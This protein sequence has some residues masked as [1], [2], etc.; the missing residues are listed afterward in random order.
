MIDVAELDIF[1]SGQDDIVLLEKFTLHKDN[2]IDGGVYSGKI[3]MNGISKD[4][5]LFNVRVPMSYPFS[6]DSI[7]IRFVCLNKIGL[8]HQNSDN[9]IC[10]V[11]PKNVNAISRLKNEIALLKEW[12]DVYYIGDKVDE[13]YDYL[14]TDYRDGASY[15]FTNLDKKFSKGQYGEFKYVELINHT[16]VSPGID[17]EQALI[18]EIGK[19][20]CAWSTLVHKKK[21]KTGWY[22][23]IDQE[24]LG[25]GI[26][27]ASNWSDLLHYLPEGFKKALCDF[28]NSK[29]NSIPVLRI[30]LG[31]NI[32]RTNEIHWQLIKIAKQDIP[33]RGVKDNNSWISELSHEQEIYW[34]KTYNASYDRFFGRGML[35]SQLAN[36]KVLICGAGAIGSSLA[37]I[38]CRGGL[39][40]LH[41][42]DNDLIEPGNICRSDYLLLENNLMKSDAMVRML[43]ATSP[44]IEAYVVDKVPKNL[45]ASEK[46]K[47]EKLLSRY[48]YIFDC[49]SDTELSW[50]F[51]NL[52]LPGA[53]INIS[54]SNKARELVCVTGNSVSKDKHIIFEKLNQNESLL[55]YE[56]TGCWSPTFEASFWDINSLLNL[57]VKNIAIKTENSERLQTF[58]IKQN[59]TS[60][61]INLMTIDY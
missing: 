31:Y 3:S 49:T 47:T 61:T 32:P 11:T 53:V 35:P 26:K 30:L 12:R 5:L 27:I 25:N 18:T 60:S 16:W 15:L 10:I 37:N 20:K 39:K 33:I 58:V 36:A 29:S 44:Y 34:S 19:F 54:I 56:G 9:S 55:F 22:V 38:L 6:N 24:P 28:K 59:A 4:D 21:Q 46:S 43:R 13:R 41:I 45:S 50:V 51:D 52:N 8:K 7:S 48:D 17:A 42:S 1:F 14:V 57:A 40:D 23:F 2:H